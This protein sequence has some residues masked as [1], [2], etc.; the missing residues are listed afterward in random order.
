M[1]DDLGIMGL[2][3]S[4]PVKR[5]ASNAEADKKIWATH[6]PGWDG[7][8]DINDLPIVS[9]E[10]VV[11]NHDNREFIHA[12]N[13]IMTIKTDIQKVETML[14][15]QDD[16]TR[17]EHTANLILIKDGDTDLQK[18]VKRSTNE[19]LNYI[20]QNAQMPCLS[21]STA[22]EPSIETSPHK[23]TLHRSSGSFP[24]VSPVPGLPA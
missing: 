1:D 5:T 8:V 9:K 19:I 10:T 23:S 22:G 18:G 12:L 16:R 6:L 21:R 2:I 24:P 17:R 3:P 7:T 14:A 20:A 11:A 4:I 15:D 13:K